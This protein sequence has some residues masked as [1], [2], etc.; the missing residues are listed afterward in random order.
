MS[1]ATRILCSGPIVIYG[2][3]WCRKNVPA[4]NVAHYRALQVAKGE[5]YDI[6]PPCNK[7]ECR[8]AP[9]AEGNKERGE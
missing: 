1:E 2:L 4:N 9:Q 6:G 8:P 5:Y 3:P 7:C